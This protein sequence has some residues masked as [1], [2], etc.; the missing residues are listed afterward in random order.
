MCLVM[1]IWLPLHGAKF[2]IWQGC[3]SSRDENI[4]SWD[5]Q[6]AANS[7]GGKCSIRKK[8][9]NFFSLRPILSFCSHVRNISQTAFSER[10]YR[11]AESVNGT[12]LSE[13]QWVVLKKIDHFYTSNLYRFAGFGISRPLSLRCKEPNATVDFSPFLQIVI[14]IPWYLGDWNTA[15]DFREKPS[16]FWAKNL[17]TPRFRLCR[18]RNFLCEDKLQRYYHWK[19]YCRWKDVNWDNDRRHGKFFWKN[20]SVFKDEWNNNECFDVMVA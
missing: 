8:L 20:K 3:N 14:K 19:I 17:K 13:T 11:L 15:T 5:E 6:K 18:T 9:E 4:T 12:A 10:S 16:S 1:F 2:K 7:F